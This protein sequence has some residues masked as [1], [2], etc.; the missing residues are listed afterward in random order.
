MSIPS[1]GSSTLRSASITSSRVGIRWSRVSRRGLVARQTDFLAAFSREEVDAVHEAQ[2]VA[3]GAHYERMRPRAVGLEPDSAQQVAVRD[4]RRDHD[5]LAGGEVVQREDPLHVLHP[6]LLRRSDLG[7]RRRPQL[8]LE[9]A[10]EAAQGR[11]RQD[12]LARPAGPDREVGVRPAHGRRDRRGDVSVLDQLDP[13]AGVADLLDQIVV[14]GAVEDDRRDVVH[15]PAERLGDRADVVAD[16]PAQVD[17]VSRARADRHLAHV[18]VRQRLEGARLADRDHRHRPVAAARDDAAALQGVEG[19]VDLG[20]PRSDRLAGREVVGVTAR[21][22]DARAVEG[23][24]L[25]REPHRGRRVVLGRLLVGAPEPARPGERGSLRDARVALAE[26][27]PAL[28]AGPVGPRLRLGLRHRAA[29]TGSAAVS[30]SSITSPIAAS[31]FPFS[32]TGTPCLRAR[33]RM[34]VW[35]SRMSSIASRYF[36]YGR[37]P[38]ES[39]S[40]IQKWLACAS[41]SLIERTHS[42]TSAPSIFGSIP[43]TRWTP[44]ITTDQPS[45]RG[46]SIA[47]RTPTSTSRVCSRKPCS[48]ASPP[49]SSSS[50]I[51]F[52]ASKLEWWI[53]GMNSREKK[54]RI[55]WRTKSGGVTRVIPS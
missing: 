46:R 28:V 1:S 4:T 43:G 27:G 30:T 38:S 54:A 36:S 45:S 12:R 37:T 44:S 8:R 14:P 32:I 5:H 52:P 22:D 25:E 42:T 10:A 49:S 2:P 53:A 23:Q 35:I 50:A 7:R 31:M 33:P 16:G 3:A 11:G 41:A 21:A 9:A 26:A 34:Y 29:S 17:R 39:L 47:A 15:H 6:G 18:H 19:E 24:L 48:T 13:R 20:P 51:A 40:R 55:V